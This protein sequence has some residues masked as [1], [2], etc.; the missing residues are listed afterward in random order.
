MKLGQITV[1]LLG[2]WS[3]GIQAGTTDSHNSCGK[4]V[5]RAASVEHRIVL[6]AR[7]MASRRVWVSTNIH[8]AEGPQVADVQVSFVYPRSAELQFSQYSLPIIADGKVGAGRFGFYFYPTWA[9][10]VL[11]ITSRQSRPF[12]LTVGLSCSQKMAPGTLPAWAR[13]EIHELIKLYVDKSYAPMQPSVLEPA[14]VDWATGAR[15]PEDLVDALR[16]ML[17]WQGDHHS[18]IYPANQWP[19]FFARFSG[20]P[21]DSELMQGVGV[22]RFRQSAYADP[23]QST[24][25]ARQVAAAVKRLAAEG[26]R[27]WIVDLRAMGG[28]DMWPVIAGLGSLLRGPIVGGF[29]SRTG[30]VAWTAQAGRSGLEGMPPIIDTGEL[31]AGDEADLSGAPVAVLIGDGT[32]SAGEAITTAFIGRA[33]TRVFGAPSAGFTNSAIQLTLFRQRYLFGIVT[34]MNADR[35]GLVHRGPLQPDVLSSPEETDQEALRWLKHNDTQVG[36]AR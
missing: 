27:L 20:N 34:A 15:S 16:N 22:L 10:G 26:A 28:G 30:S 1:I 9:D 2:I 35:T 13:R 25:Y 24:E 32:R 4:T 3:S 7:E 21:F 8:S 18:Y 14:T 29:S 17:V 19:Q 36:V 23:S 6:S 11:S 31:P 12:S 5:R 33:N